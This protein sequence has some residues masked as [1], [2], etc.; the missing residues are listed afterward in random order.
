MDFRKLVMKDKGEY[1]STQ[2]IS[3]FIDD[4][5]TIDLRIYPI[6]LPNALSYEQSICR[7]HMITAKGRNWF[8]VGKPFFR[9]LDGNMRT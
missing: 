6:C 8:S 4:K 1:S 5:L 7:K 9:A 3:S 2:R